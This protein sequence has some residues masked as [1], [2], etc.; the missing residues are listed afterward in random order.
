MENKEYFESFE[1]NLTESLVEYCISVGAIN[2]ILIDVEELDEKWTEIAPE[3]MVDAIPNFNDYPTVAI[4]WAGYVGVAMAYIWDT[5]WS[6]YSEVNNI[7]KMIS[8]PRTFD[9][10]DEYIV[11]DILGLSLEDESAQKLENTL[12]SCAQM[13]NSMMRKEGIQPM[14]SE[15]FHVYA[16]TVKV[17]YKLGITIELNRLGYEY[18]LAGSE[19]LN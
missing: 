11:E 2:S 12:R 10:M 8:E 14:S 4:A 15:A 5:D 17:F 3:Y 13:A 1:Q 7:Y 18:T 6:K 16:H 9:A 19:Y